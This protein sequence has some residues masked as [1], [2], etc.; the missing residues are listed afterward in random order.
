MLIS[1]LGLILVC[2][3]WS[4][5]RV[6]GLG[7]D[8]GDEVIHNILEAKTAKEVWKKNRSLYEKEYDKQV[9]REDVI[10]QF[11]YE[12]G[13]KYVGASQHVYMLNT[14]L[15]SFGV[16]YEDEDKAL[17]LLASL[18]TH[19]DRLM[20]TL[21]YGKETAVL[22]EVTSALSSHVKMKQDDDGS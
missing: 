17:L 15:L 9:V 3:S 10:V 20:T 8:I 5:I 7:R 1:S 18:P 12:G 21:I 2:R 19:F 13:F 14:Q 4:Q 22:N 6:S 16:N 11:A